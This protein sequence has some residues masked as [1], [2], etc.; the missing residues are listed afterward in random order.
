MV[1]RWKNAHKSPGLGLTQSTST[2]PGALLRISAAAAR[3]RSMMA[4]RSSGPASRRSSARPPLL[5]I[6]SPRHDRR[7]LRALRAQG[8]SRADAR[9]DA[10]PT[11]LGGVPESR[12]D[13]P[14][15]PAVSVRGRRLP[16]LQ[17][18]VRLY[19]GMSAKTRIPHAVGAAAGI[20]LE[21][22]GVERDLQKRADLVHDRCRF[23]NQ[24]LIRDSGPPG[25]IDTPQ[26][27]QDMQVCAGPDPLREYPGVRFR[28]GPSRAPSV[29]S[30][31][32]KRLDDR[33]G[34]PYQVDIARRT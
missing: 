7:A 27:I 21:H 4:C 5:L 9:R 32:D 22:R 13:L 24:R 12:G 11:S 23:C 2:W 19:A 3:S 1:A 10:K 25:G 28:R 20:G 18:Q 16:P 14:R 34:I 6:A 29:K 15:D 17:G 26:E 30:H 33:A 8:A 31:P